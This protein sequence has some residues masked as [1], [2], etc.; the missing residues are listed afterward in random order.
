VRIDI[1]NKRYIKLKMNTKQQNVFSHSNWMSYNLRHN[2]I[3]LTDP[4]GWVKME[5]LA[6]LSPDRN[7]YS[8]SVIVDNMLV[9]VSKDKKNR[10]ALNYDSSMIRATNGHS[11]KLTDSIMRR[12]NANESFEWVI[13]AT[14]KESWEKIQQYGALSR[15]SRDYVHFAIVPSHL[16]NFD[17]YL[18]L[19]MK[20]FI[21]DGN[22]LWITTNNVI[23]S[24]VDV[25]LRYLSVGSRPTL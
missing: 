9:V 5:T 18:Y 1:N 17:I 20:T 6:N 4:S 13:H 16:R 11:V 2:K 12:L 14:T 8:I 7:L 22:E 3:I 25:P 10:Y 19:D 23:G 24:L 15:M 21:N